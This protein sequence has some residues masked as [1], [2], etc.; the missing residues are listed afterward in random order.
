MTIDRETEQSLKMPTL[1]IIDQ[2]VFSLE[3]ANSFNTHTRISK[4]KME[5]TE[6]E[7]KPEEL[8]SQT[9]HATPIHDFISSNQ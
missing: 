3:K 9:N 8:F 7:L 1:G 5:Q 6:E 4:N 2:N